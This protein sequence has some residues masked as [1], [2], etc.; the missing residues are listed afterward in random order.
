MNRREIWTAVPRVEKYKIDAAAVQILE[1]IRFILFRDDSFKN[2]QS[3]MRRF[4]RERSA[5]LTY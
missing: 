5:T 3:N 4:I 2:G 1:K